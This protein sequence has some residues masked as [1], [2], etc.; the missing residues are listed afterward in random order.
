MEPIKQILSSETTFL[1]IVKAIDVGGYGYVAIVN[2]KDR[3]LGMVTDGD[4]RRCLLNSKQT[5][6]ALINKSPLTISSSAPAEEAIAT[7]KEHHLKHMPVVDGNNILLRMIALGEDDFTTK[8]NVVVIMAGGLGTRLGELTKNTPKPMLKVGGRPI[9]Q[10]IVEQFRDYGYRKFIMC[11]SY[12]KEV[13]EEYF[14]D[15]KKFGVNISYVNEHKRLGT[16]GALS[17]LPNSLSA[18][19]FVIN[20]DV[21]SNVNYD[22]LVASHHDSHAVATMCVRKYSHQI[23]Y[24]VIECTEDGEVFDIKEKPSCHFNINAGI[25]IFDPKAIKTVPS[26]TFYDMPQF[27]LDLKESIGKL[28]S[29]T[30]DDYWID[31]GQPLDYELAQKSLDVN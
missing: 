16:A 17:L 14:Q 26:D 11:T 18:P 27:L 2:S 10:H 12:K 9:I 23:P 22:D 13:I 24:G 31:I 8:N 4:V 15:G 19:F 29:Y 1:D 6:S 25:Y 28:N 7:L 5:I 21:L 30:I 3:L 20:A